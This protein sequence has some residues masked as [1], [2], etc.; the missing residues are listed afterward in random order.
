MRRGPRRADHFTILSNA[1][2]NDERLSFRARGILIWLLSKPADW[3]T[4]SEAIAEQSPREGREAIRTAMRELAELGYL[5]REKVQ[6]ERGQWATIQTVYE[7]PVIDHQ[8]EPRKPGRGDADNGDPDAH[9][10]NRS[11]R[12]DTN[13]NAPAPARPSRPAPARETSSSKLDELEAATTAAGL[14]ASY[15]RIRSEQHAEIE[16]L[17][18][19]HGV[20][21]LVAAAAAA[22]RP[23]SPTMHVHGW[24]RLWQSLPTPRRTVTVPKCDDCEGTGFVLNDDDLAIRCSC[25]MA[26]AA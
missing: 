5:V 20:D 7:V 26:A 14:P 10:K 16:R 8:P 13:N 23:A 6:N 11:L 25:R 24:L 15:R 18:E 21:A 1:V 22:H 4:R 17:L 2:L 3:R 19:L 12:T 9:T